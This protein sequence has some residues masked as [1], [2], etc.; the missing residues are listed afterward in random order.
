[1]KLIN[2]SKD[3]IFVLD[4]FFFLAENQKFSFSQQGN[5][6]GKI[7]GKVFIIRDI[8]APSENSA[9]KCGKMF[10]LAFIVCFSMGKES[11]LFLWRNK[12]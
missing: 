4:R 7:C 6:P 5:C 10:G 12:K 8:L 9:A 11:A 1:M 3:S 2:Q